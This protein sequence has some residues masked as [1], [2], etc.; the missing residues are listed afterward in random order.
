MLLIFPAVLAQENATTSNATSSIPVCPSE[1]SVKSQ[2]CS[3]GSTVSCQPKCDIATGNIIDCYPSCPAAVAPSTSAQQSTTVAQPVCAQV[4]TYA[5]S[6]EGK[7]EQFSNSCIPSGWKAVSACPATQYLKE[8]VNCIFKNSKLTQECYSSDGKFRCSGVETC[9][10]DAS[11]ETGYGI[12]WKS[13]CGG[14]AYTKIDGLNENAEFDCIQT[15]TVSAQLPQGCK[16]IKDATTGIINVV[17]ETPAVCPAFTDYDINKCRNYGGIPNFFSDS[18]GCKIFECKFQSQQVTT[19]PSIISPQATAACLSEEQ[20]QQTSEKCANYGGVPFTR[21]D[22]SGCIFVEC[23]KETTQEKICPSPESL[24][25][26][27]QSCIQ[28]GGKIV[29]DYDQNSCEI[30]RCLPPAG[31]CP[32]EDENKKHMAE[33]EQSK[34]V[35]VPAFDNAGCKIIKCVQPGSEKPKDACVP[36]PKEAFEK[37][38]QEGGEMVI[39]N[40]ENGCSIYTKCVKRGDDTSIAYEE[41][42]QIPSSSALLSFAFKLEQLK[43]DFDKLSKQTDGIADYYASAGNSAEE[44][45]FRKVSSMFDASVSRIDEIKTKISSRVKSLTKDDIAEF[46]HDLI[47]IKEVV[48]QDILYVM[49]STEASSGETVSANATKK[50]F[51]ECGKNDECFNKMLRTCEKAI[52]YADI[53]MPDGSMGKGEITITGTENNN[54]IIKAFVADSSGKAYDMLCSYPD[55]VM[56]VSSSES[57][58]SSCKGNMVD[59]IKEAKA[60]SEVIGQTQSAERPIKA[61]ASAENSAEKIR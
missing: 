23:K 16:E 3:D 12:T 9:T 28:A 51:A 10:A 19:T 49:L 24:S 1:I 38:N 2:I 36:P 11:G 34:M 33:C 32:S 39:K 52:S 47:Y 22:F 57:F 18:R 60:K 6:S 43:I 27:K 42:G 26:K 56:G 25:E 5:V 17:C 48:I 37:C 21:K 15:P 45:R 41:V 4:I 53:S 31:M 58:L 20:R 61:S 8:Q 30:L 55:Y 59:L 29:P 54:C 35:T 40:D 46:K 50:G 13:S 14:Y 44:Q 7:C